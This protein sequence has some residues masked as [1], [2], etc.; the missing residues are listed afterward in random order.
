MRPGLYVVTSEKNGFSVALVDGVQV[1]V[2]ARLRVDL[3]MSVGQL[4]E[5]VE[6]SVVSTAGRDR[7]EPARP[8]DQR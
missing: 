7:F 5:K 6:V 3:R 1:Q 8:G 4:S 2:G